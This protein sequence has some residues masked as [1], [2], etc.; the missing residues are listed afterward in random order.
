MTMVQ[1]AILADAV[2][3]IGAHARHTGMTSFLRK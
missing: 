3:R 1:V 2:T